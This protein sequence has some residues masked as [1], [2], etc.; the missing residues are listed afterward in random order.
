MKKLLTAAVLTG[1][2]GAAAQADFL[3]VEMGGGAWMQEPSGT[4]SYEDEGWKGADTI[5]KD[6]TTKAYAWLLIKHP[7]PIVPN[8]RL[9][10]TGISSE[11][12]TTVQ[13]VVGPPVT[14][15]TTTQFDATEYDAILYYNLLDNTFWMTLDLGID[16][17]MFDY[18][19]DVTPVA[20]TY[21]G[22]KSKDSFIVPMGYL[23]TRVEVPAT[24][25]GFEADIKYI[26]NGDTQIYDARIKVDYTLDFV[27]VVQPALEVGYRIQKLDIDE[28]DTDNVNVD[29]EFSGIYAGLMLRF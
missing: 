22:Y 25:I 23:R 15:L 18:T 5:R 6:D 24:D 27:P 9:E 14:T 4:M 29:I 20:G 10:Y 11:S 7:V 12:D 13:T 21:D 2:I 1:M 28:K 26:G 3:R 17:R 16:I 8:L 19:Y